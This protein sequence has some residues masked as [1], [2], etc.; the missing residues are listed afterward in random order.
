MYLQMEKAHSKLPADA[1]NALRR[2]LRGE[3][4]VSPDD[5]FTCLRSLPHGH[6][7]AVLATVRK[8]GLAA[9]LARSPGRSWRPVS[10][11]GCR[12]SSSPASC[13]GGRLELTSRLPA[14]A[15]L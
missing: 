8:L 2:I 15:A 9:L 5:A 11:G 10:S 13:S 3:R 4:L 6:V 14:H 12:T 7:A 1:I